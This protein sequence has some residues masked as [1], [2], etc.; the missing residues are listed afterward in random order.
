MDKTVKYFMVNAKT[1]KVDKKKTKELDEANR[2]FDEVSQEKY[3]KEIREWDGE[4]IT[5]DKKKQLKEKYPNTSIMKIK[6]IARGVQKLG[7]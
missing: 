6:R 7:R 3:K 2:F 4:T 5:P 1:G